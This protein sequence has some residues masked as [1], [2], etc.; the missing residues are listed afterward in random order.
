MTRTL[1][2]ES[3]MEIVVKWDMIGGDYLLTTDVAEAFWPFLTREFGN[4]I[5][6]DILVKVLKVYDW[7]SNSEEQS[8]N[9]NIDV[10]A[11]GYLHIPDGS[12]K[13][14][15]SAEFYGGGLKIMLDCTNMNISGRINST[16]FKTAYVE[17]TY[18]I[19]RY[20]ATAFTLNIVKFGALAVINGKNMLGKGVILPGNFS[21]LNIE[22]VYLGYFEDYMLVGLT[23]H[24]KKA[25]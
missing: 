1:L 16:D 7:Q 12:R 19:G 21:I 18:G 4:A 15:G 25:K 10:R 9:F 22:D 5:P 17:T 2:D 13:L 14:V 8:I 3:P 6:V 11:E 20:E 23:P 24:F